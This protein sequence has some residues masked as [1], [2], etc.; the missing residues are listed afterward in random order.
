MGWRVFWQVTAI[1]KKELLIW[2]RTGEDGPEWSW[3]TAS[4][5]SLGQEPCCLPTWSFHIRLIGVSR[6]EMRSASI[7]LALI[8]PVW[9]LSISCRHRRPPLW[10]LRLGPGIRRDC[11][12]PSED[13]F[14]EPV[15]HYGGKEG[16]R[17][18]LNYSFIYL[19]IFAG[20]WAKCWR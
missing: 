20:H 7:C 17:R 15:S 13:Y 1:K 4:W 6:V 19:H 16:E 8:C 18:W 9:T 10:K 3:W 5:V 14:V 12:H 2:S 11:F